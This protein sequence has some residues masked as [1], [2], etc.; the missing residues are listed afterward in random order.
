MAEDELVDLTDYAILMGMR[1]K[2]FTPEQVGYEEA[3]EDSPYRCSSCIH[4]FRRN[5]DGLATCEIMRSE[6]TDKDGV[7]PDYRCRFWTVTGDEF[8][9]LEDEHK[10][11][12]R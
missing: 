7:R 4:F 2:K 6:E 8:P 10:E 1:P 11:S 5:Y 9:L 3:D 12:T